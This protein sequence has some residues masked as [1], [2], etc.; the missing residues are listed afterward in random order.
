MEGKKSVLFLINTLRDGG[1]EK[2]LVDLVN[3]LDPEK[4]DIEVRLIYRHGVYLDKLHESV[5]LT[6]VS[7]K[8]G[9]LKA[10]IVSRLLPL[11]S[12]KILH[13]L[14]IRGSYDTEIAFL[15]GYAT[16]VI[17]GASKCQRKI[18][19]VHCDLTKTEWIDGVF[20]SEQEQIECY[21]Q[22]DTVVCVSNSVQVAFKER[23]GDLSTTCVKYNPIDDDRIRL[24]SSDKTTR[25]A[26]KKTLT[27]FSMGRMS[28]PKNYL[29]LLKT[30]HHFQ[31]AGMQLEL[32]LLGDGP[33]RAELEQYVNDNT[34]RNVWMPGF[35][36]NPYPYLSAADLYVCS[37]V[38]EGYSTAVSEAL[39]L[40][41]P[42]MTTDVAGMRELLGNSEYGLI[43][44]N[45]DKAFEEGLKQLLNDPSLLQFYKKRSVERGKNFEMSQA[46][47][48][49]EEL[50]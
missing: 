15:E 42:V 14:I 5:K 39:I 18:A 11:L 10:R 24:L 26:S 33:Q 34:V 37:S 29:R 45:E 36:D 13:R 20:K 23:I 8:I 1:A 30:I 27:L 44:E 47:K 19:W 48:A 50:L 17:A 41:V 7:G 22:F 49:I 31:Q 6:C 28:Y 9:T 12:S 4:Y 2:I 35:I 21:K 43:V 16:K 3:H 25:S 38:Y 32:W 40:G 46:I